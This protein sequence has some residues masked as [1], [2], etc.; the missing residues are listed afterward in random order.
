MSDGIAMRRAKSLGGKAAVRD[1]VENH[2]ADDR[3]RRRLARPGAGR[4]GGD[5]RLGASRARTMP[6]KGRIE[7]RDY[8]AAEREA[9]AAERQ[10]SVDALCGLLGA[11]TRDVFLNDRAYWRNVPINVWEY[12]IGGYQVMKKWLSYRERDILGR[13]LQPDEAREVMHVA[14]HIAAIFLLQPQLDAN[15]RRAK[16]AAFNWST[17]TTG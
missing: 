3:G 7:T 9:L 16:D 4:P 14:R 17:V 10:T 11:S 15:Y 8:D 1:P 2:R 6:A 13:D 5:R 12:T